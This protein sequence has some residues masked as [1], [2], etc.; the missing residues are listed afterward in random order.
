[1]VT[2]SVAPISAELA[3]PAETVQ[4]TIGAMPAGR[5]SYVELPRLA[6][7]KHTTVLLRVQV[8]DAGVASTSQTVTLVTAG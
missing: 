7:P 6:V 4:A 5:S 2:A 1:V 3:T 8:S